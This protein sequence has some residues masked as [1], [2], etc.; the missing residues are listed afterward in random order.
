MTGQQN[1]VK[2]YGEKTKGLLRYAASL[3][4]YLQKWE[5]V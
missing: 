4:K 2:L 3:F 1:T 5:L